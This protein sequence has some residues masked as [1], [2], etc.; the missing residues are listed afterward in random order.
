MDVTWDPVNAKLYVIGLPAAGLVVRLNPDGSGATVLVND[1]SQAGSLG[2]I[3]VD[4]ARGY[5]YTT[6]VSTVVDFN[7]GINRF[8]LDGSGH[9]DFVS[10]DDLYG[11]LSGNTVS[12]PDLVSILPP[13]NST[14]WD[15]ATSARR[16]V[17]W[18]ALRRAAR[19]RSCS[20]A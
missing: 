11:P 9:T 17:G 3:A 13:A 6:S 16:A 10:R 7:A 4:A 14:Q 20:T 12:A 1:V 18:C 19:S 5:I 15:T 8:K 2:A